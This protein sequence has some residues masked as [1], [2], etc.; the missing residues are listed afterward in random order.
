MNLLLSSNGKSECKV[1]PAIKKWVQ[2]KNDNN[3][4]I[5]AVK[6]DN[7]VDVRDEVVVVEEKTMEKE[8]M[9]DDPEFNINHYNI[10]TKHRQS[11]ANKVTSKKAEKGYTLSEEKC[12]DCDMNLLL[13]SNGKSECKVCP[14]IKKW[15]QRK[16]DNNNTIAAVKKDNNV[17]V[18]DEVVVVEEKT[19]EKEEMRDDP[20]E[21]INPSINTSVSV[22]SLVE[23]FE[24]IKVV[25]ETAKS[26]NNSLTSVGSTDSDDTDAI[27]ERARQ[28]IM[29]AR[30]AN[31]WDDNKDDSDLS[32]A[33]EEVEE[34][35]EDG[36]DF[37]NKSSS[38]DFST[39]AENVDIKTTFSSDSMED[40]FLQQRAAAIINQARMNLQATTSDES[41]GDDSDGDKDDSAS[42]DE[43]EEEDQE[44]ENLS[45]PESPEEVVDETEAE[46][47]QSSSNIHEEHEASAEETDP[48]MELHDAAITI[49]STTRGFLTKKQVLGLMFREYEEE[50]NLDEFETLGVNNPTEETDDD[51]KEEEHQYVDVDI[52]VD[53]QEDESIQEPG[54][55]EP[56]PQQEKNI[57]SVDVQQSEAAVQLTP[58]AP[59]SESLE[60]SERFDTI[61]EMVIHDINQMK[62]A[63]SP[64]VQEMKKAFNSSQQKLSSTD[65]GKT[66]KS[67]GFFAELAFKFDD[68]V[69]GALGRAVSCNN[70]DSML[71][72]GE[73]YD[74][75]IEQGRAKYD[76]Q[77]M[78][79]VMQGWI[80]SHKSCHRCN[81]NF[82]LNP[83]DG[84]MMCA[85]CDD[86]GIINPDLP[87][88][89]TYAPPSSQLVAVPEHLGGHNDWVNDAP[90]V[91]YHSP[92]AN[93]DME[94]SSGDANVSKQ[95]QDA[96]LRIEDAKKF[97]VSR[98]NNNHR[99]TPIGAHTAASPSRS[100]LGNM[101]PKHP[102]SNQVSSPSYYSQTYN[103]GMGSLMSAESNMTPGGTPNSGYRTPVVPDKV[104]F[105]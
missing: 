101:I 89:E 90:V 30:N 40:A 82:M 59:E 2:R 79:L 17:D 96:K 5:A 104:F 37:D 27:R 43:V 53:I 19:M 24:N 4:T 92:H 26:S 63:I 81:K 77:L 64:V 9:R 55:V 16:N 91:T 83:E 48:G 100:V 71:G 36:D 22:E 3:N 105:A 54:M 70:V 21:Y 57:E 86:V 31:K 29:N 49:Q 62:N 23:H 20:E 33:E 35:S 61:D 95:L 51:E 38:T 7:N 85:G 39:S 58:V 72:F 14:A 56:E 47:N 75:L 76:A 88:A 97:I 11:I 98:N 103:N 102:A 87:P 18:R 80:D 50:T 73:E 68:A 60:T 1:C 15:V 6:K 41:N 12:T 66:A 69:S 10:Q 94:N 93:D 46:V 44:Q 84:D 13:S 28:I 74:E 32:D 25:Q 99:M 45:S 42:M 78:L 67:R 65:I 34:E 8:E 52:S